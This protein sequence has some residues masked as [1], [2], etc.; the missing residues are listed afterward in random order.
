MLTMPGYFTLSSPKVWLYIPQLVMQRT[1]NGHFAILK[2]SRGATQG[3]LTEYLI[4]WLRFVL[5]L[6]PLRHEV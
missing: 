5:F 1:N 3:L 4:D 6:L 2:G